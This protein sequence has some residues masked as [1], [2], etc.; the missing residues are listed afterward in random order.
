M[1]KCLPA[2]R[3]DGTLQKQ[4]LIIVT[5]FRLRTFRSLL[6]Q[7]DGFNAILAPN[8][9]S[10]LLGMM[11]IQSVI[12]CQPAA[13]YGRQR[14][15]GRQRRRLRRD[16][17]RTRRLPRQTSCR[18]SSSDFTA[19][20]I[21]RQFLSTCDEIALLANGT[22]MAT[23]GETSPAETAAEELAV[24]AGNARLNTMRLQ[25]GISPNT[26]LEGGTHSRARWSSPWPP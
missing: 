2:R 13:K 14:N 25:S 23:C 26:R 3:D 22:P 19:K 6:T 4:S 9:C 18:W 8:N 24:A 12:G 5:S 17:R 15:S 7:R 21:S 10:S 11:T 16:C 20:H 1:P